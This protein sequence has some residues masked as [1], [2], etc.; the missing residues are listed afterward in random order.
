MDASKVTELLQMQN[1]VYIN[2]SK[3]VDSSTLTWQEQLRSSTYIKGVATCTG[4]KNTNVPTQSVCSNSDGTCSYG[5][6]GK[7]MTLAT[8]STQQY[9]SVFSGAVGSASQVYSSDSVLL[10][11]AGLNVCS[12]ALTQQPDASYIQLPKCY[13]INTNGPTP[14]N[15]T[16]S[17]NNQDTNP[18]LPPFDTYYQFKNNLITTPIQDENKKS[19]V[20]VCDT[21]VMTPSS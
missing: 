4:A 17:I 14:S 8:G 16:P 6:K 2:R 10:Q 13:T 3:T 21:C 5:G 15:P 1:T 20:N 11:Q 7:Q 19:F 9:P 12:G 18:Y